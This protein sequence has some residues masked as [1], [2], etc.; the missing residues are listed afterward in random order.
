MKKER[1]KQAKKN[2]QS[3]TKE[4]G[5]LWLELS[6]SL[7][8]PLETP[9]PIVFHS[10]HW[11]HRLQYYALYLEGKRVLPQPSLCPFIVGKACWSHMVNMHKY[12]SSSMYQHG[13]MAC[14]L[15]ILKLRTPNKDELFY[16]DDKVITVFNISFKFLTVTSATQINTAIHIK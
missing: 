6:Y 7:N 14:F 5:N 1:K 2:Q 11:Q 4:R 3:H 16:V 10:I 12:C 9:Y 8:P 15:L 13:L